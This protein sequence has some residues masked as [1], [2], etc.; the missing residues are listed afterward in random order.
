MA[1]GDL[2]NEVKNFIE[3]YID[4]VEQINVLRLLSAQDTRYFSIQEIVHELRSTET[5]ILRR[6]SDLQ[7]RKV[8]IPPLTGE[9]SKQIMF[10]PTSEEIRTGVNLLVNA[11]LEKPAQVI[12]YIYSIPPVAVREFA[13][14]FQFRKETK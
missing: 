3:N 10:S 8:L 1:Y 9:N 13:K 14:A 4:S 7:N 2:S 11:F 12:E 5:A 6:M